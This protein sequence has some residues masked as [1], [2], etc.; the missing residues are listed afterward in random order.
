MFLCQAVS[1]FISGRQQPVVH[2]V[3]IDFSGIPHFKD[4]AVD[5]MKSTL[6]FKFDTDILSAL[7][8]FLM[9]E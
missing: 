2:L 8:K 1:F 5:F 7:A 6:W 9:E 4:G 3:V